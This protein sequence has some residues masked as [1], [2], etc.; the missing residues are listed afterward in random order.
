MLLPKGY[1]CHIKFDGDTLRD[2][3]FQIIKR[4]EKF[5]LGCMRDNLR[6]LGLREGLTYHKPRLREIIS[7]RVAGALGW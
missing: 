3:V 2:D 5:H 4:D 7:W 6:I 1:S